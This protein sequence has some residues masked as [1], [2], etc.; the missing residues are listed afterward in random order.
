[1]LSMHQYI[2]RDGVKKLLLSLGVFSLL[3]FAESRADFKENLKALES[4][5]NDAPAWAPHKK[6]EKAK[7]RNEKN[8]EVKEEG[9]MKDLNSLEPNQEEA[10]SWAKARRKKEAGKVQ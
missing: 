7:R 4:N 5:P 10:P 6:K 8:A 3:G 2:G 1:M 9:F